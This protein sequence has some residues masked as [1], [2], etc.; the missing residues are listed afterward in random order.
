MYQITQKISSLYKA[1]ILTFIQVA[2]KS[3]LLKCDLEESG[4][5]KPRHRQI[6]WC[7]NSN[8]LLILCYD[9]SL[10]GY[11]SAVGKVFGPVFLP[12]KRGAVVRGASTSASERCFN[13]FPVDKR[14]SA[15]SPT[16]QDQQDSSITFHAVYS[17]GYASTCVLSISRSN[18]TATVHFQS[19]F[20]VPNLKSIE[21]VVYLQQ[22]GFLVL[23]GSVSNKEN[24]SIFILRSGVKT[25]IAYI[26][27]LRLISRQLR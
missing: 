18:S 26:L 17:S 14:C 13:I 20:Q 16:L 9:G 27:R 6:Q 5:L 23:V 24:A 21:S 19:S 7:P 3:I 11:D 10:Y 15:L 12:A 1:T 22:R 25:W 2:S 4:K 8:I